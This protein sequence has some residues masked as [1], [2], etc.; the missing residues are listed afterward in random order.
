MIGTTISHYK[1]IDK[2][3]EGGMG[4][5]YKAHDTKLDRTVA[6]KFLPSRLGTDE[7][8]KQR[9]INEAKAA[10]A[11]DHSNI[12]AIHSIDET[13]DG[14]LFI[15]MAYYE[16]M[17]LKQKIEEG[18]L[19]LKDV[20]NYTIQIVSG[21]QKAHEKGV[22]HRDLK[23]AN[24]FITIDDQVKIIDFGLA[25]AAEQALLTKSG[26]TLGTVPYMSPEQARGEKVDHRTD[27]W[28]LGVVMYEMIT[29]QR[30][31]KSDYEMALVYS[32]I[33]EDPLPVTEISPE[34]PGS[35]DTIVMKCLEK[36]PDHRYQQMNDLIQ[37]L[38]QINQSPEPEKEK[39]KDIPSIAVLPFVNMNR[40]DD[41]EFFCD[42]ITEDISMALTKL[43]GLNVAAHNSSFQFKG[44]T[45]D[46]KEVGRTLKVNTVLMGSLRSAGNRLRFNVQLSD[47]RDGYVIWSERY[48]RVMED[49]FDIQDQISH[50]VVDA[51]KVELVGNEK[52]KLKKRSTEDIEAYNLYLKGRYYWNQRT[53]ESIRKAKQHFERALTEDENY[54]LAHSGKAD[55]FAS[56]GLF[57]VV[58]P[59]EVLDEGRTAALKAIEIDPDLAEGHTSLAFIEAVYNWKWQFADRKFQ[60]AKT[61]DP[62]YATAPFWRAIFVLSPNGRHDE[63]LTEARLARR[64][65][66]TAA[67]IDSG[68]AMVYF[69]ANKF[70]EAIRAAKQTLELDPALLGANWMLGRAL[71]QTGEV[72]NALDVFDKVKD[73]NMKQGSI[74]YAYAVAGEKEKAYEIVNNMVQSEIPDYIKAYHIAIIYSGLN[75]RD[76]VFQWLEKAIEEHCPL[77]LWNCRGPEFNN[78]R[79]DSRWKNLMDRMGLPA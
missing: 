74:G 77:L 30:P 55:C 31:F 61:L 32:I 46:L 18:P 72:Q 75:E 36:D 13:D 9:F 39:Q 34:V 19:P 15:V 67:I 6:L 42:G 4:V 21:I 5:V 11:L 2:L 29:R 25:K 27:I 33:K 59:Q 35:I 24:I 62:N 65:N 79:N 12:C 60:Q 52:Q 78:V 1:V 54:A 56:I 3:G 22:I 28:A 71:V 66:P 49:I 45:P 43:D 69:Y 58:S 14:N 40:N 38:D 7:T 48:D 16:G 53:P 47:V 64:L 41:T 68:L 8:E 17:S 76:E 57:G 70:N 73:V 26:T 23:P 10:S 50:A 37:E 51:L 44:K 63:A 20:V